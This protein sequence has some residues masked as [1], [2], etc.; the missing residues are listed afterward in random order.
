M[1]N[2]A[3]EVSVMS[4]ATSMAGDRAKQF[5]TFRLQGK[6]FGLDIR[7]IKEII[8]YAKVTSVPLVQHFMRGV[9][10]LRGKVVPVVD[11]PMRFG[12]P[13]SPVT[14]RSCI[15][16]IEVEHEQEMLDFGLVIDSISEVLE[17]ADAD[18]QPPPSFGAQIRTDFIAGMGKLHE[19]FIVLLNANMVLS[20]DELSMLGQLAE[21]QVSHAV[22]D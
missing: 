15:V 8:Q 3:T 9:F 19:E 17:L 4:S 7:P 2:G 6:M 16:I 20:V 5:L 13:S 10:N 12:W 22:A 21:P 1:E 14:N 11:L 18:I